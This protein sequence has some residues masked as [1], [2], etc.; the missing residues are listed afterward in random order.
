[1]NSLYADLIA[2]ERAKIEVLRTKI[3]A[4]E[5]RIAVLQSMDGDD[6]LDK[7]LE[8]QVGQSAEKQPTEDLFADGK[9]GTSLEDAT[10]SNMVE[11]EGQTV[12]PMEFPRRAL[13]PKTLKI[14]RFASTTDK[15]IGDFYAFVNSNGILWE[16]RRIKSF[17]NLYK[18]RYGLLESDRKGFF[19]LSAHGVSYLNSLKSDD[20]F[21]GEGTTSAA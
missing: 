14:L 12:P 19:R 4:C 9:L 3:D 10:Q 8:K 17:L 18:S 7:L 21:S 16:R 5:K 13:D 2:K 11:S 20:T 15:S 1:M 6:D